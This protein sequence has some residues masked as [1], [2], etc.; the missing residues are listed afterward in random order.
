MTV[1][2]VGFQVYHWTAADKDCWKWLLVDLETG[3]VLLSTSPTSM[4]ETEC[5]AEIDTLRIDLSDAPISHVEGRP[6]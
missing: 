2:K 4:T 5:D 1:S 6:F 3:D